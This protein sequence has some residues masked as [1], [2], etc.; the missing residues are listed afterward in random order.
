[1]VVHIPTE[2]IGVLTITVYSIM[3]R[4]KLGVSTLDVRNNGSLGLQEVRL[5]FAAVFL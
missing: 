4:K 3:C 1:M 5:A 2:G